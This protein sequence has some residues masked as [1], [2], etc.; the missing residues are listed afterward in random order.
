MATAG[1]IAKITKGKNP[2]HIV[3]YALKKSHQPEIIGGNLLG[4]NT[5]ELVKEFQHSLLL[6]PEITKPVFHVALSFGKNFHATDTL[7]RDMVDDY[8]A[9]MGWDLEKSQFLIVRHNDT[10]HTHC[11]VIASRIQLDGC[12]VTEPHLDYRLSQK[13]CRD[14]EQKYGLELGSNEPRPVRTQQKHERSMIERTGTDSIKVQLQTQIAEAATVCST[15][16]EFI[17]EL[18]RRDIGLL[19]NMSLTTGRVAG[20]S[21]RRGDFPMKGSALGKAF[22]WKGLQRYFKLN[23]DPERDTPQLK[24]VFAQ[25]TRRSQSA[26]NAAVGHEHTRQETT[27][28]VTPGLIDFTE[29]FERVAKSLGSPN[30]KTGEFGGQTESDSQST[31][32]V[33]STFNQLGAEF[34]QLAQRLRG[35][36][37]GA[38]AEAAVPSTDRTVDPTRQR[39]KRDQ[40][41]HTETTR[42]SAQE[43]PLQVE[44]QPGDIHLQRDTGNVRSS[45]SHHRNNDLGVSDDYSTRDSVQDQWQS[46]QHRDSLAADRAAANRAAAEEVNATPSR[47]GEQRSN[48]A[49]SP[50]LQPEDI[51]AVRTRYR[52]LYLKYEK[53][54][55]SEVE[56]T[57]TF[58]IDIKVA[59]LALQD[60]ERDSFQE[61]AGVL[62]QSTYVNSMQQQGATTD[63]VI[64]HIRQTLNYAKARLSLKDDQFQKAFEVANVARYC[65]NKSATANRIHGDTYHL[66]REGDELIVKAHPD[67]RADSTGEK[68]EILRVR[69]VRTKTGRKGLFLLHSELNEQDRQHFEGVRQQLNQAEAQRQTKRQLKTKQK[70]TPQK[71]QQLEL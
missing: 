67:R 5:L 14:L 29:Q 31:Q 2:D 50:Q 70:P 66:E 7:M 45:G 65:L 47:S 55:R 25:E 37:K 18:E 62:A 4:Q 27:V 42:V 30:L 15:M 22:S 39:S 46:Q 26:A 10:E 57:D 11:H 6:R 13:I 36:Q 43:V 54:V 68:S 71:P 44:P 56:F 61:A 51:K 34:E 1:L 32:P 64:Q 33:A 28:A 17:Q 49:P 41:H 9:R 69:E 59:Q 19:P 58:A 16:S 8:L 52:Q 24:R 20:V 21:Y 23:Y 38:P 53:Q 40:S 63:E 48:T 35:D 3:R 12:L 60:Q